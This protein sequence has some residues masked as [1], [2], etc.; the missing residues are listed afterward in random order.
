M[1]WAQIDLIPQSFSRIEFAKC[2]GKLRESQG[3]THQWCPFSPR[4]KVLP[5]AND[6]VMNRHFSQ[7]KNILILSVNVNI[8]FSRLQLQSIHGFIH[9]VIFSNWI[10][11]TGSQWIWT[12][13]GSTEYEVGTPWMGPKSATVHHAHSYIYTHSYLGAVFS[14]ICSKGCWRKPK[15]T[16]VDMEGGV[17]AKGSNPMF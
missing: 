4:N 13:P 10:I 2:N 15:E 9:S 8:H 3:M 12:Y 17:H 14:H 6:Q 5:C 7:S 11:W 16:H 1:A